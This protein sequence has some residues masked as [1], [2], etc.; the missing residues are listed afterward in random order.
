MVNTIY[1]DLIPTLLP[2]YITQSIKNGHIEGKRTKLLL[3][4]FSPKSDYLAIYNLPKSKNNLT[5][6]N[7]YFL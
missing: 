3:Y 5:L 4:P 7:D 1:F 6:L 2:Q